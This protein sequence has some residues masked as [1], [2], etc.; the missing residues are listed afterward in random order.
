M[1]DVIHSKELEKDSYNYNS[2]G[3]DLDFGP[4]II[5]RVT[6]DPNRKAIITEDVEYLEV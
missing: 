4:W 1:C 5:G 2:N 6:E 3:E